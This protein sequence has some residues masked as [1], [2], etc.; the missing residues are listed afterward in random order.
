MEDKINAGRRLIEY[1]ASLRK[2]A[3]ITTKEVSK[4]TGVKSQYIS[5]L[6]SGTTSPTLNSFIG[7]LDGIECE[8]EIVRKD[9]KNDYKALAERLVEAFEDKDHAAVAQAIAD[10]KIT[11][12]KDKMR[13]EMDELD[14]AEFEL[15]LEAEKKAETA[16]TIAQQKRSK[17]QA[18]RLKAYG[19]AA[20]ETKKQKG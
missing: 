13:Q 17:S 5:R 19:K 16:I 4:K 10:M 11:L 2:D 12:L 3:G 20:K 18:K 14:Q 7:Y 15:I 1:A 9:R 8:I 6:E